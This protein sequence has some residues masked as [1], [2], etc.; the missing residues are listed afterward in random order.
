MAVVLAALSAVAIAYLPS[1]RIPF[2]FDDFFA[3]VENPTLA[4]G[5]FSTAAW[6]PPGGEA[7]TTVQGRPLLNASFAA[8]H[9][10]GGL[11]P[12]GYHALN[13]AIHLANA[14]L[15]AIVLRGLLRSPRFRAVFPE[16]APER[17]ALATA[18]LWALHPMQVLAVSYVVQRAESLASGF[19]LGTLAAWIAARERPDR[20]PAWVTLSV[21]CAALGMLTKEIVA[22]APFVVLVLDRVLFHHPAQPAPRALRW[23]RPALVATAGLLVA[24]LAVNGFSRGG[25]TG[26]ALVSRGEYLRTQAYAIP[27]YVGRILWPH[28]VVFDHGTRIVDD[29]A[30]LALA[31]LAWVA[32]GTG[33]GW[34]VA[35]R[36]VG[37]AVTLGL[38][39]VLLAPTSSVVPI[40]T[41]TIAEHRVYLAS[42]IVIAGGVVTGWAYARR[43]RLERAAVA[44]WLAAC[45]VL[46]AATFRLNR[47]LQDEQRLW[48]RVARQVPGN[49]RAYS[50]LGRLAAARGDDRAAIAAYDRVLALDPEQVRARYNRGNARA[51]IGD[52]QGAA[53]DYRA[54]L[55]IEPRHAHARNN[56][57]MVLRRSGDRAGALRELEAVV[58][59]APDHASAWYNLA[60][61]RL[62]LGEPRAGLEAAERY[63]SLRPDAPKGWRLAGDLHERLGDAPRA[64]EARLRAQAANR[65]LEPSRRPAAG[66]RGGRAAP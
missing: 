66:S 29:P 44:L 17:L 55:R 26:T 16:P 27:L 56:L 54:L 12:F 24:I 1:F 23:G 15:V 18:T 38:F 7:G 47:E 64:R 57:A 46:G 39:F 3:I 31:A 41:Q 4:G 49:W 35:R 37:A 58:A 59:A 65:A 45:V 11:D 21:A 2:L 63:L 25:T 40:A 53:D 13:L 43:W 6:R 14:V 10:L 20:A 34:L 52:A 32:M 33:L 9:A 8:S 60:L 28:G 48:E 5:P 50:A 62:E 19:Y 42:G 36:A 30:R 22:T 51:R 61:V